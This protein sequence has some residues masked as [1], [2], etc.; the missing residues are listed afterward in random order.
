MVITYPSDPAGACLAQHGRWTPRVEQERY[1]PAHRH[2]LSDDRTYVVVLTRW[3]EPDETGS[4]RPEGLDVFETP[5]YGL[6]LE[7]V[8]RERAALATFGPRRAFAVIDT[9]YADGCRCLG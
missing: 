3:H 8:R 1:E 7:R 9:R 5:D 6:A 2:G 4:S